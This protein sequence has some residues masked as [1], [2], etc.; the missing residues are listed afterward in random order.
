MASQLERQMQELIRPV[1]E[2]EVSRYL[3]KVIR[4]LGTEGVEV[5]STAAKGKGLYATEDFNDGEVL[6]KEPPFVAGQ[7]ALNRSKAVVCANC[8]RF[9]GSV[10]LQI[11][12]HLLCD[13]YEGQPIVPDINLLKQLQA[14]KSHL[15]GSEKFSLPAPV[16]C[17]GHC[18]HEIFCSPMCA[19]TAWESHHR[20]LCD[21]GSQSARGEAR[22]SGSISHVVVPAK[23][24]ALAAFR[25]HADATND[26]FHLAAKVVAGTLLDAE[27]VLEQ[28]PAHGNETAE[29]ANWRALRTAWQ[30]IAAGFKAIWWKSVAL[31]ED[32]FD[33][34]DFRA[35]L[36]DLASQ[37]LG[38][39]KNCLFDPRFPALF[40]LDVYGSIIGMFELNN[41]DVVVAS[42]VE[43]FFLMIDGLPAAS[44]VEAEKLTG[45]LLDALDKSYDTPCEGT[46]FYSLQ[47]C[48]N[49]SCDPNAQALKGDDDID[50]QAVIVVKKPIGKGDEITISYID[51]LMPYKQRQEALRDY[52][53]TCSCKVCLEERGTAASRPASSMNAAPQASSDSE[54]DDED[55][56]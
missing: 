49:H 21:G 56:D 6:L 39:L 29:E 11:A 33:E 20:L 12:W 22:L 16:E 28:Y 18:Q 24:A 50:G 7:H 4:T 26:I 9:L 31:P 42:P 8:F 55:D 25:E 10:E 54:E 3:R 51:E 23:A 35:N 52:G 19:Q 1:S 40:C 13:K 2:Q 47:S 37:S 14:S 34:D 44:K 30:P 41:L 36:K 5:R 27:S 46:A 45:P 53:F 17:P 38:L 32:V 43:D 15:P 48:I